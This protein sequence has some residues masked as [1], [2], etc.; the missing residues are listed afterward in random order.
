[1]VSLLV[2]LLSIGVKHVQT[3]SYSLIKGFL[4]VQL[5]T[6]TALA[7]L[8]AGQIVVTIQTFSTDCISE[9]CYDAENKVVSIAIVD[10]ICVFLSLLEV[11]YSLGFRDSLWQV[12]EGQ[13]QRIIRN[14][15]QT[16]NSSYGTLPG[17]ASP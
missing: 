15:K 16:P 8:L 11:M 6:T 2:V 3:L 12:I 14:F 9:A 7:I 1:M 4:L 13:A 10:G 5:T 17:T